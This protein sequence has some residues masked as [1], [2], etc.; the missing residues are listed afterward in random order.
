MYGYEWTEEYGIFRL[1]IDAK[2][3]KEIRPVFKEEL[4]F[5]ELYE[6]WDYPDTDQPLLWAEGVRRYILNGVCVAEVQGGGIYTKPTVI[7]KTAERLRLAPIDVKRLYEINEPLMKGLEQRAIAFIRKEYEEYSQRNYAFVCAFSGGKDSIVLLDLCSQALA[8]N[9]FH[10]VFSN[11]GMELFD[12]YK[13]V[14]RAKQRWKEYRFL[15]AKSDM[16]ASETWEKIGPPASRLRWC[17]GTF[18]SVPTVMLLKSISGENTRAVVF[19]GVRAEESLRRSKYEEIADGIKNSQQINC[20]AILKWSAAEVFV[21]ILGNNLMINDAY[22]KGIYR[23]GC[24]ICPMSAKWQDSLIAFNYPEDVKPYLLLLEKI[25]IKAKGRLDKKYIE[26]GGWKART[27]GRIL[28]QGETRVFET[29]N[30][31]CIQLSIQNATQ[32][33]QNALPIFGVVVDSY[34]HKMTIK[35]RNGEFE[36][37]YS[38]KENKQIIE[39]GSYKKLDRYEISALRGIA[40]KTAYCIGC[41]ACVPQCPTG[42][43][44]IIDGKIQIR[45]EKCVHCYN[46]ITYTDKSCVVAKSLQVKVNNM[47]NP[48]QYKNFGFRQAFLDHFMTKGIACFEMKS[49]GTGQYFALRHWLNEAGIITSSDKKS[50]SITA[51][52]EKLMT[53]GAYNP[54]TW[55]IVWSNLAYNSV[56]CHCFCLNA[57][58]GSAYQEADLADMIDDTYSPTTRG[59]AAA[60]L[61]N[62]F[63]DSPIGSYL[64]QGLVVTKGTY[65]RDGWSMPDGVVLLYSLYLYAEHTG[66]HSFTLTE[67]IKVHST[68]D[69]PGVSPAD[70]FGFDGK[71]LRE[72]IQGLALTYPEYIRVSFIND[73]DN[74]V[75]DG[76][77]TSLSILDLAEEN[78]GGN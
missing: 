25:T 11:T 33:W 19:D 41:K 36:M 7:L 47:G 74:I 23:V 40:N 38:Q 27:G 6:Q 15:E 22:K 4:D 60:A 46:C 26:D 28:P 78:K 1:T 58:G 31:D 48:D 43:F 56:V 62:T 14:E 3:Q 77:R 49:L 65:L 20:H 45:Y 68:P 76:K 24:M 67:L 34:K 70:I 21:Y 37:T 61:T 57:E 71:R 8:P 42:A 9:E 63:R 16:S 75:L 30:N 5:F 55:A 39:I 64:G 18:K 35:S 69:A 2:I 13:A 51:L 72:Y 12:T 50:L 52:G 53:W 59:N 10:V 66:R 32:Q 73:L 17:C 29:I 54:L 44:Q